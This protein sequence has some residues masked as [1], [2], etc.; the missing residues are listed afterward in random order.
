MS[1]SS[2]LLWQ[3]FLLCQGADSLIS[4]LMGWETSLVQIHLHHI[5]PLLNRVFI[6]S[7]VTIHTVGVNDQAHLRS[8][9]VS[10]A[11]TLPGLDEG[12]Y[13]WVNGGW[14]ASRGLAIDSS[15]WLPNSP[16]RSHSFQ[17]VFS[18]LTAGV[19]N[20]GSSGGVSVKSFGSKGPSLVYM[21]ALLWTTLSMLNKPLPLST[22]GVTYIKGI[23]TSQNKWTY[24]NEI[25]PQKKVSQI[26]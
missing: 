10:C 13:Y 23:L 22:S 21:V 14:L 17:G 26:A 1:C 18:V 16:I 24:Q 7:I 15:I 12:G 5:N 2:I 8:R 6:I 20:K 25:T 3:Y 4:L 11:S 9:V 19:E